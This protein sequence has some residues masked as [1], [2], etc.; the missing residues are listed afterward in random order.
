MRTRIPKFSS[1]VYRT[2]E[3]I[4]N[5]KH[6]KKERDKLKRVTRWINK[7]E[8]KTPEVLIGANFGR[9]GGVRN[10]I[11]AIQHFSTLNI[12]LAPSEELMNF[13]SGGEFEHKYNG[14]FENCVPKNVKAIHSHVYPWFIS[15]CK[16]RK[17][18]GIR[19]IHTYH[20]PYFPEHAEGDMHSWQ[21]E[22]NKALENDAK[23]ADVRI[24]VA[25]WQ[26]KYLKQNLNIDTIY[27]PNGVNV[28]LCDQANAKAFAD[29]IGYDNFILNVS[30]HDPVKNPAEFVK[31]A[32]A[33]PHYKFVMIGHE[34]SNEL[35]LSQYKVEVPNNL[36]VYG[37][38]SQAKVQDAIAAC[39]IL[40]STA[41]REGLPTLVL[42][43][44]AQ[45]KV[46]LVANEPGSMEA[47]SD[48]LYGY[49]YELGNMKDLCYKTELALNDKQKGN[50]ARQRV[51][52]EFDWRVVSKKLDAI[53]LGKD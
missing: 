15:W 1:I 16:K 14:V 9:T 36:L 32:T 49:Y 3:L 30:R 43:G 5:L 38:A 23:L 53:Y 48:G 21:I 33:M 6:K 28:P 24:S 45:S 20:L 35:L 2:N 27:I 31:L 50:K 22:I 44:M 52:E 42:E 34:L 8:R 7:L 11:H 47:I 37:G 40:V 4:E 17:K 25:Q 46:V 41:K 10:H 18:D 26:Q 51:L 12:E 39:S 13:I 19:W 29:E